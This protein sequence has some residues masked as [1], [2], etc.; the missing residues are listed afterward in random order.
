RVTDVVSQNTAGI[1]YLMKKNKITVIN[2][3]A[4]FTD[5]NTISVTSDKQNQIISSDKFVIATGSKPVSLPGVEIDK[6][7][8]ITSTEAL[9]LGEIPKHMIVIGGGVIGMELGS[10]YARLGA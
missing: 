1:A 3:H 8:I 10:V 4:T 2:G 6:E 7:R 5:A 9:K